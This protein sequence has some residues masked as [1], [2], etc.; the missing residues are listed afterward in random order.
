LAKIERYQRIMS[1]VFVLSFDVYK[2]PCF[3]YSL[4][5]AAKAKDFLLSISL[6]F[7]GDTSGFVSSFY[8]SSLEGSSDQVRNFERS[9]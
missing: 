9:R 5:D 2:Q 1:N 4:I 7:A 3:V 6:L 8:T